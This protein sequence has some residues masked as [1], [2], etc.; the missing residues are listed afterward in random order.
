[1]PD[2]F[3]ILEHRRETVHWDVMFEVGDVLRTWAVDAPVEPGVKLAARPL[4]DHR[5]AYLDYEGPISG[6]RGE[7]RRVASGT[8]ATLEWLDDRVVLSLTGD[9]VSGLLMLMRDGGGGWLLGLDPG[10]VD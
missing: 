9:Q 10:N 3:V 7:V 1:M 6:D 8:F 2:R 5:I 4:P